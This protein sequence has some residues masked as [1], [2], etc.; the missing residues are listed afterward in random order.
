MAD[1]DLAWETLNSR[2]GYNCPGFDVY[3]ED[4]RFPNGDVDEFDSLSEKEAVVVLPFT[5]GR[6]RGGHRR[7]ATAG[8]GRKPRAPRRLDRG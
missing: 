4:V 3:S 5:P 2:A 7:V 8:Q 1:D 6:G